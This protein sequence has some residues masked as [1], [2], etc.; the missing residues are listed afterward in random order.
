VRWFLVHDYLVNLDGVDAVVIERDGAHL[1][2]RSGRTLYISAAEAR[3][4][5]A[6]LGYDYDAARDRAERERMRV[7]E[8]DE[9]LDLDEELDEV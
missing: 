9:P 2:L 1:S 5:F 7:A 4:L 6:A 8:F 3:E